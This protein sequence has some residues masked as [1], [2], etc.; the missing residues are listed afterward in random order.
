MVRLWRML[1]VVW[2]AG[3]L[4]SATVYRTGNVVTVPAGTTIADDLL[5]SGNTVTIDARVA[6]DLV[7]AGNTVT[8]SGPVGGNLIVAGGTVQVRGP[9]AGTIYAA[10]GT[11]EVHGT[12]K[13][14]MVVAGGTVVVGSDARVARDLTVTGGTTTVAGAVG[15]NVLASAG[16]LT[17]AS[18]A[19][20]AGDL[21]ASTGQ[22]KV[23]SGAVIGGQQ[24]IKEPSK[25]K[26][27]GAGAA[28]WL[29]SR[30]FTAIGL[31]LLGLL[32]I[33]V[34]PRFTRET[35]GL[36]IVHPWGSL[37]AGFLTLVLGPLALLIL[38]ATIIGIPLALVLL[39]LWLA[40]VAVGPVFVAILIGHAVLRRTEN[41]YAALGAGVLVLL[42][43]RFI[44]VVSGIVSFFAF[45]FG[46]GALVLTLQAR[47]AHPY[48]QRPEPPGPVAAE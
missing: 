12:A 42:L 2:C 18:T 20:I 17:V 10:G 34:A 37:L 35:Q 43:L 6:N 19:R 11:V 30:L 14:N 16:T 33:A 27:K 24:V 26:A 8:V 13:R 25:E 36:L 22:P 44:P 38:L 31:F 48:F 21:T 9:V 45:L 15:R 28:A 4:A 40:A 46:L 5:A 32:T 29:M 1:L 23:E 39:W 41:L 3:L 47:T 7:V